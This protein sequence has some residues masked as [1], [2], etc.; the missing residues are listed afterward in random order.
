MK[1]PER[2]KLLA[3]LR[4]LELQ[5]PEAEPRKPQY[6]LAPQSTRWRDE[7]RRGELVLIDRAILR[8]IIT[9]MEQP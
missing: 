4:T 7:L 6:I 3:L 9:A 2:R 1:A 8:A 5:L